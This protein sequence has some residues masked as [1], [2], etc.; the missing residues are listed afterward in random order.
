MNYPNV[1]DK[2]PYWRELEKLSKEEKK[3]LIA[4]LSMSIADTKEQETV[5]DRTQEMIERCCGSWVGEQTAEE[6]LANIN[7]SKM[8]KPEPVKFD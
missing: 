3:T 2:I 5:R 4:M 7:G 8:S 6:I 1:A